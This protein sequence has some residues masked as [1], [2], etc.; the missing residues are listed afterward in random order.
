MTAFVNE[1]EYPALASTCVSGSLSS[2]SSASLRYEF[3]QQKLAGMDVHVAGDAE[4]RAYVRNRHS[5]E[6]FFRTFAAF[7]LFVHGAVGARLY[8]DKNRNDVYTY[9]VLV[10]DGST[11][12]YNTPFAAFDGTLASHVFSIPMSTSIETGTYGSFS[13]DRIRTTQ[14]YSCPDDHVFR[15]TKSGGSISNNEY[16]DIKAAIAPRLSFPESF[17]FDSKNLYCKRIEASSNTVIF[18]IKD[19][20]NAPTRTYEGKPNCG[21]YVIHLLSDIQNKYP[22]SGYNKGW[23]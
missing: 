6:R 3:S 8:L 12:P 23:E 1:V 13:V 11:N 16:N 10:G 19:G 9:A 2:G 17:E 7:R 14:G 22:Y 20:D 18:V 5:G 15:I 4:L 21:Y